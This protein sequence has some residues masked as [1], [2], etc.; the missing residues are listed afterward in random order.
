MLR[1]ENVAVQR[2]N[3]EV[4]SD[5]SLTVESGQIHSLLGPNGAGKSSLLQAAIGV[6]SYSG[7]IAGNEQIGYLTQ[8]APLP[9]PMTVSDFVQLGGYSNAV[10]LSNV[11]A[12]LG[13]TQYLDT[14]ATQ[15]SGGQYARARIA[16]V[17]MGDAPVL[18]FD[19]PVAHLDPAH[20]LGLMNLFRQLAA[21]G[22]AV[23]IVLHDLTLASR[24]SDQVSLLRAGQLIATGQPRK[25]LT[26]AN[27]SQVFG[28]EARRHADEAGDYWVP[29]SQPMEEKHA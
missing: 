19:E 22:R 3:T 10:R 23:G 21:E 29:W 5:L 9:W 2:G 17:L 15:L 27:L 6:L 13:L 11:A 20:Q 12:K 8:S 26:P 28:I 18:L 14:P 7:R 25:V 4:V 1:F 16:R 24:F